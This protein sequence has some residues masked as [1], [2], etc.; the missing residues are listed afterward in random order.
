MGGELT[1]MQREAGQNNIGMV[2]WRCHMK[3]PEYPD[4]R[5]M[6][7][8]GNDLTIK[9]GSFGVLEDELFQKAS[10]LARDLKIPR[11]YIA[12]NSGARLGCVEE[13][14]KIF[15][16]AWV[17]PADPN[18]G[19][20]YLYLD[21][22]DMARLPSDS[23]T[24]HEVA[25]NGQV[26]HVL[27][28][29]MGLNLKSTQGGIGVENLQGSGLI[30]GETSRAYEETFTL[31]YVTGRSVGI[32]AYLNR[33]GQRNIQM[34]KGP[35][36]LTGYQALNS[37]LGQQV[38]TSQDQLGGP[39]IMVPNG[40]THEL[41][42]NDQDGVEAILRW[43]AFVPD[44]VTSVPP[45]LSAMDPID[46]E[47]QFMPTKS[48]YDPRHMLAGVKIAGEFQ[49]G[50]CDEG[51]FH[52]YME[53]W[54]KTVVVGRGRVGGLP[55]G[56]VAVETRSVVRH[57]PADPA[58]S[59]SHDIQEAQA[60]QVWFPD[61]AFKTAQAIRDFNRGENLPLIIFAN[62]RGFSGGTRDMYQEVLKFGAQIVDAL[63]DYKHPVFVYIPPNGE[64]R[65]GAW[66]VIDPAINPQQMEMYADK[67][68]RGG[69]LE[70]PAAA[71]IVFKRDAHVIEMMYRCDETLKRLKSE[72]DSGKDVATELKAREKLLLPMYRQVSVMYCDLHD[73]SARMKSLGAIHEELE[74]RQSRTYLHWRIRRRLCESGV[75]KK[76]QAAVP[77]FSHAEAK[78]VLQGL[79]EGSLERDIDNDQI[80]AQWLEAHKE[81]VDTCVEEQRRKHAEAQIFDLLSS[82][83]PHKQEEV[84]R[85][86]LGFTKVNKRTAAQRG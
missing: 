29:I 39:H 23:V 34:V 12:C 65:G 55:V 73:R 82:L 17:D 31:S 2:T 20:E 26:R 80:V 71:E 61:S 47:I 5:E 86:L 42:R 44:R 45:I 66:V 56:I 15:Q 19:F 74:W 40:V 41:V 51:S 38:Y 25:V 35:M 63:V 8:I 43:L 79:L 81:E 78:S 64:L 84:A 33:L 49:P 46:R 67:D 59:T 83:P 53:G 48:P 21:P 37:V 50:F 14:K 72:K 22:N 57:I 16:V 10:A 75:I 68:A 24:S 52:E 13:L 36:I 69:I 30:A 58:D 3:T 27:D 62:W 9:A 60:G 4:G 70:P 76:I 11:I 18:K 32:G 7:L 28:A 6:I 77:D 54:G 1:P 85:D